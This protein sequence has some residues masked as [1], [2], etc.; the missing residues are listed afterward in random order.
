LGGLAV[1]LFGSASAIHIGASG[2]VFGLVG[3]LLFIGLFRREW[4]A[5]AVSAAVFFFYGG[6]L[7]SLLQL[8]PGVSWSSH[9]YGFLAGVLAAWRTKTK[10]PPPYR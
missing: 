2:V 4:V 1:W 9:F 10:L 3:Y 8:T 5:L 7:L 6:A